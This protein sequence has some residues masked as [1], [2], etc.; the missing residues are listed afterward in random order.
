MTLV[1]ESYSLLDFCDFPP[2]HVNLLNLT[3]DMIMTEWVI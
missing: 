1:K 3:H 2:L